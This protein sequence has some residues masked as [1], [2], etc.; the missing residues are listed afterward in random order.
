MDAKKDE[1]SEASRLIVVADEAES[2][3]SNR[4]YTRRSN[5][6]PVLT[7]QQG[8]WCHQRVKAWLLFLLSQAVW[9]DN[10]YLDSVRHL[11]NVAVRLRPG[12]C[13][14]M[15]EFLGSVVPVQVRRLEV[16]FLVG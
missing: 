11:H 10:F 15:R 3:I 9:T 4:H 1:P 8:F 13:A 16:A 2:P 7:Q 6:L 14:L 12:L 5:Y